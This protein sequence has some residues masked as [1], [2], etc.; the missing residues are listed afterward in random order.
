M[1]NIS[2][3]ILLVL[4]TS[5]LKSTEDL[6]REQL[7]DQLDVQ[8]QQSQKMMAD[9][10]LKIKDFEQRV[11]T[12]GGQVE[13]LEHNQS[14]SIEQKISEI[15]KLIGELKIKI[16]ELETKV[17]SQD[18]EIAGVNALLSEQ[19]S[20]VKKVTKTLGGL[21]Q[22]QTDYKGNLATALKLVDQ[23]KYKEAKPKLEELLAEK[24][25]AAD[26]NK[27]YHGLGLV[28]YNSK[29]YDEAIVFFS[30]I[31]TKWP[32]SSLSPNSL[33]YIGKSFESQGKKEEAKQIFQEVINKYPKS[34]QAKNAQENLTKI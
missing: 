9:L 3:L 29:N 16:S 25:S 15:N 33:Y 2:L 12:V 31:Y 22:T 6:R 10:T 7:V 1:K 13:T 5:C 18:K 4:F 26:K 19:K 24:L 8:M 21:A 27:V 30:K 34:S 28:Q 11:A 20:Y 32:R 17:E 23:K 14:Q